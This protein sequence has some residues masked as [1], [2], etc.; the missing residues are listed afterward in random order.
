MANETFDCYTIGTFKDLLAK[1]Y[2]KKEL[3]Y[4]ST[5]RC[6]CTTISHQ[7]FTQSNPNLLLI[8]STFT[9]ES[10]LHQTKRISKLLSFNNLEKERFKGPI[11][12][13]R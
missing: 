5:T 13:K 9:P 8:G 12:Y 6:S 1:A 7:L 10:K 4:L 2:H 11:S 3:E